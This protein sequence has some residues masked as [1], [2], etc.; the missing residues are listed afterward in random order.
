V[1]LA[2]PQAAVD[3]PGQIITHGLHQHDQ[4][5]NDGQ[6]HFRHEALIEPSPELSDDAAISEV[7]FPERIRNG[8]LAA[9]IK[10]FGKAREMSDRALLARPDFGTTSVVQ[11]PEMLALGVRP[12]TK[13]RS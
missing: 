2:V 11:L 8:L 7:R 6:H 1:P 5:D 9:G 3:P 10:T 13:K 4:D 12:G